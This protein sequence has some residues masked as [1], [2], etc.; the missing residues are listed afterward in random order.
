MPDL[1]EGV[2][3]GA[4]SDAPA[5]YGLHA[6][7]SLQVTRNGSLQVTGEAESFTLQIATALTTHPSEIAGA[8][9]LAGIAQAQ[10]NANA[11]ETVDASKITREDALNGTQQRLAWYSGHRIERH[12]FNRCVDRHLHHLLRLLLYLLRT[13]AGRAGEVGH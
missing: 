3:R 1:A 2:P 4:I 12:D 6:S 5:H 13:E 10:A 11:K 8:S 9:E 7:R